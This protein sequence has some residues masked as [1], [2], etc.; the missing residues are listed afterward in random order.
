MGREEIVKTIL[1]DAEEDARKIIAQAEEHAAA[2][3]QAASDEA[4][5][6]LGETQAETA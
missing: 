1:A 5:K 3:R 6:L 4:D 2:V